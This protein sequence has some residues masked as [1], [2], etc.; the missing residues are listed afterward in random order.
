MIRL[1][2]YIYYRISHVYDRVRNEENDWYYDYL[3][4][5][6]CH[7]KG[8]T[9]TGLLIGLNL[10]SLLICIKK[11][12]LINM[13]NPLFGHN[14]VWVL[15]FIGLGIILSNQKN[16]EELKEVY[17]DE[18]FKVLKGWLVVIYIIASFILYFYI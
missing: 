17:K 3:I 16:Y 10:Q 14:R 2:K 7:I 15:T 13:D 11:N 12:L 8:G 5:G 1:I 18:K 9:I 4:K 6:M